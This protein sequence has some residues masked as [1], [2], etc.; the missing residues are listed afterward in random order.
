MNF[1][2]QLAAYCRLRDKLGWRELRGFTSS[3]TPGAPGNDCWMQRRGLAVWINPSSG[4]N[5]GIKNHVG[6]GYGGLENRSTK[7]L[8]HPPR[9]KMTLEEI[10]PLWVDAVFTPGPRID[11]RLQSRLIYI[12]DELGLLAELKTP[13]TSTPTPNN[14][15]STSAAIASSSSM[16][17]ASA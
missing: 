3:A 1:E 4:L 10:L 5:I 8:N 15:N 7:G 9:S 17:I 2:E 11:F 13:C 14:T 6:S 16:T 12:L